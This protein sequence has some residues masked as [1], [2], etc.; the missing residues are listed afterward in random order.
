MKA[1]R[2]CGFGKASMEERILEE[3]L[4]VEELFGQAV[5]K[6]EGLPVDIVFNKATLNV[7][8]GMVA[9]QTYPYDDGEQYITK[10]ICSLKPSGF[11]L[12][13]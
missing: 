3:S 5:G 1:L 10:Q 7:V 11:K 13:T 2:D 9:G 12:Q 8:W 4:R 6:D